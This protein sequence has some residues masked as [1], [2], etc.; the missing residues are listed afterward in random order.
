MARHAW[1]ESLDLFRGAD[2]VGTLSPDD[3]SAMSEVAFWAGHAVEAIE[4][5]Q[6]ACA[7]YVESR[8]L[9]E[10]AAAAA[11]ACRL[12]LQHGDVSVA[13][14]WLG[15]VQ[16]LA[17]DLP[18]CAAHG[19]LAWLE[20][21][22]MMVLNGNVQGLERAAQ[23]EEIGNK[24]GD[25]DLTALG[26]SMQGF[27]RSRTGEVTAGMRL[28]DEALAAAMAGELGP[29]A[30]AEIFCE[31]VVACLDVTDFQRAAEWLETADRAGQD[32]VCFPGCCRVHRATVLRHRG[33]W[34]AA[35]VQARQAYS[36]LEGLEVL[37][38]GMALCELGELYRGKGERQLAER[39]FEAAHEKGSSPQP[40]MALVMLANGD[41]AGASRMI[42]SA[43]ERFDEEPGNLLRLLPAQVEIAI[44]CDDLAAADAAAT[45][46][47]EIGAALDTTAA[48]AASTNAAGLLLQKQG[49]LVESARQLEQSVRLWHAARNP[50]ESARSRVRLATVLEA[51]GDAGSANLELSSARRTF[52]RLGAIQD[53]Q[54]A[55][56]RLG[57]LTPR[58]TAC[59]FMFT[60]IVDSTNLLTTI[61]DDSWHSLREWHDR[62]LGS[63]VN[64]Y[65]GR[66]VKGTGDGFFAAFLDPALAVECGIAIQRRFDEH[67]RRHGFAPSLRIGLHMGA[68]MAIDEDYAGKDVVIAA[69]IGALASSDQILISAD[70]A[71]HIDEII[72]TRDRHPVA[73]K[74]I[75]HEIVVA[76]V[77]WR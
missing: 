64:E 12:N 57:D 41:A 74:G 77:D 13:S 26:I 16:R 32:L 47:A 28:I 70:L 35:T 40:G 19:H 63:L 53:A 48:T 43:V 37:H 36:E 24:I 22:M 50:F 30:T 2:A 66:I 38:E 34:E 45:R 10:A 31:M 61:G 73:L 7:A 42:Q 25:H 55:A 54:E 3:L 69:R 29:F 23:V 67:R 51:L 18:I 62:T 15:R 58:R 46:L 21:Q 68:A 33:D 20:G 60:D 1:Q 56:R 8:S 75:P 59:T 4:A 76:T 52:E 14:G 17:A 6:R 5:S 65:Q 39:T 27:I 49:D 9:P 71:D 44:A 72:P 11:V